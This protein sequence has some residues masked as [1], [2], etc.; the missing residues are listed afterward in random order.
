MSTVVR[1]SVATHKTACLR[2]S[3]FTTQQIIELHITVNMSEDYWV[4]SRMCCGEW[5]KEIGIICSQKFK[6]KIPTCDSA[7]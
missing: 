7:I 4:G 3:K 2:C 1:P 5:K 6:I